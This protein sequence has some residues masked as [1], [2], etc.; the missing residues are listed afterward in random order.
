MMD[1]IGFA[2]FL[3]GLIATLGWLVRQLLSHQR[4]VRAAKI[5]TDLHAKLLERVQSAEDIKTYLQSAGLTRFITDAPAQ[6]PDAKPGTLFGRVISTLQAGIVLVSA[7]VGAIVA[8]RQHFLA[9]ADDL[10]VVGGMLILA[11]GCGF[12]LA[13]G[14]AFIVSQRLGVLAPPPSARPDDGSPV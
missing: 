4:W 10:L 14:A 11:L 8:G 5:Q 2:A 6:L 1:P 12:V 7:G 9:R 13:A 3:V